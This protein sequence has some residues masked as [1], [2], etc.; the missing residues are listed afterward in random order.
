MA[1]VIQEKGLGD[2]LQPFMEPIAKAGWSH[3]ADVLQQRTK[4]RLE[5]GQNRQKQK[6]IEAM[7]HWAST[8]DPSK[9]PMENIGTLEQAIKASGGD[10]SVVQPILQE[11][12]K[13]SVSQQGNVYGAHQEFGLQPTGQPAVQPQNMSD[14][15]AVDPSQSQGQP[16]DVMSQFSN[17]DLVR[18]AASQNP[19]VQRAAKAEIEKRKLDQAISEADRKYHTQFAIKQEEKVS[20]LRESL[21][22][23]I[24]SLRHAR[25][26]IDSRQ[27]GALSLNNL[28]NITGVDAFRTAKG[29]ELVTA[30][31]ENLLSNMS[32]VSAKGQNIWFEQRLASM[33]P[34]VGQTEEAN[35]A[36][37]EML[38]SETF[39]DE[40]YLKK[41]DEIAAADEAQFGYPRKDVDRRARQAVEHL[42]DIAFNR[43]AYRIRQLEEREMGS[44]GMAK[45]ITKK[46]PSGTPLTIA[47]GKLFLKKYGDPKKASDHAKKLGYTIPDAQELKLYLMTPE[48]FSKT[49]RGL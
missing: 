28:A 45:A 13:T 7:T 27:V 25:N 14:V 37:Q 2:L 30:G 19:I 36:I 23:K 31:K 47:T 15:G 3:L 16:Q 29:G 5:E 8:Y 17:A 34:L 10:M 9:S 32:R 22:K 49:I 21:P 44:T 4:T 24:A 46:V 39:M 11:L 6:S 41:F 1:T 38:E 20:S 35:L 48:E 40:A 43:S 42:E 12:L 33:F 18:K 26:A